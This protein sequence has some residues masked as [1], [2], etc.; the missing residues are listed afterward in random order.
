MVVLF[1]YD[2][3]II[4][5]YRYT[6]ISNYPYIELY[7]N[8]VEVFYNYVVECVPRFKLVITIVSHYLKS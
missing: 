3:P 5:I 4:L 8:K 7:E 2:V 1:K 6:A